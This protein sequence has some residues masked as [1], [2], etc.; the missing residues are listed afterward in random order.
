MNVATCYTLLLLREHRVILEWDA[1]LRCYQFFEFSLFNQWVFISLEYIWFALAVMRRICCGWDGNVC[2]GMSVGAVTAGV[3]GAR[4]PQYDIWGSCVNVARCLQR[5]SLPNCIHVNKPLT[6]LF[7]GCFPYQHF[8]L[9][10]S[11]IFPGTRLLKKT[12]CA[13]Q[14]LKICFG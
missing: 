14:T 7:V 9:Y 13:E 6:S 11:H 1:A 8:L 2:A 5:T 4:K 10:Y 3:V 12:R